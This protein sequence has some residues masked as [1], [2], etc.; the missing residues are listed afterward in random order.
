MTE[1]AA[2]STVPPSDSPWR[3]M[4]ELAAHYRITVD[5]ARYWRKR[6]YGPHGQRVGQHVRY[7]VDEIA[8]FDHV[9]AGEL[10]EALSA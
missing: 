8:R 2:E 3:T 4:D 6:N 1:T 7:H 10:A 5:T 9:L